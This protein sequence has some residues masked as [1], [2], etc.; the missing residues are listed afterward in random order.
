M[1]AQLIPE[2]DFRGPGCTD[3]CEVVK[4]IVPG[5]FG[6]SELLL[7][8]PS[9][10]EAYGR[11]TSG[12]ARDG[13][14]VVETGGLRIDRWRRAAFAFGVDVELTGGEWKLLDFLAGHADRYV[15]TAELA[16]VVMGEWGAHHSFHVYMARLRSRLG[17][18]SY[19]I[20]TRFGHGYR[21]R[22]LPPTE[23]APPS[24][25]WSG[26][27]AFC[28]CCGGTKRPHSGHGRCVRCRSSGSRTAHYGPCGA[29]PRGSDGT[30]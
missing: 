28:V 9:A 26:A 14:F 29:P 27:H 15:P 2:R 18:A 3:A 20:E 17:A 11:A 23:T 8:D 22:L 4:A 16:R 13:G 10:H 24:P 19:L 1:V 30:P 5:R 21:L 25:P 7:H 12:G 6:R